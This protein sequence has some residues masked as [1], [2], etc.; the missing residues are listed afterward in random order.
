MKK[1][2]ERINKIRAKKNK[3]EQQREEEEKLRSKML[4][5]KIHI[6]LSRVAK[7][8]ISLNLEFE[9]LLN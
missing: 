8:K 3:I 7:L 4:C 6:N 5:I 1:F 9:S 2:R